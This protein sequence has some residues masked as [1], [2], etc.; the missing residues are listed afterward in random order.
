MKMI[1]TILITFLV[2]IFFGFPGSVDARNSQKQYNHNGSSH[3]YDKRKRHLKRYDQ[4]YPTYKR[5]K[6]NKRKHHRK[7]PSWKNYQRRLQHRFNFSPKRHYHRYNKSYGNNYTFSEGWELIRK[8]RPDK[9]LDIFRRI[10]I[11]SPY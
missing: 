7:T 6:H 4:S 2:G 9:T 11:N 3:T 8:D 10:A 1:I 5:Y